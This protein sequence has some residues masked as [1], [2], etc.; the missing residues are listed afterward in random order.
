MAGHKETSGGNSLTLALE[1]RGERKKVR[2]QGETEEKETDSKKEL[3]NEG[4]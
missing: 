4:K 2:R 3:I 1:K